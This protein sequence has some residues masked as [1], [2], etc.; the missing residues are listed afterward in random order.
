M[1][2]FK[3]VLKGI[4]IFLVVMFIIGILNPPDE[5]KK[6][7]EEPVKIAE[8]VETKET[9]KEES[10]EVNDTEKEELAKELEETKKELEE[11]KKELENKETQEEIKD[12]EKEVKEDENKPVDDTNIDIAIAIIEDS[13]KGS[14]E[15]DVNKED[16]IINLIPEGDFKT[17]VTIFISTGKNQPELHEAWDTVVTSMET[18]SEN[19]AKYDLDYIL[20]IT[21]PVN[22]ENSIL[23]AKN[24]VIIYNVVDEF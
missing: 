7:T 22:D 1:K 2:R 19:V 6:E 24:G 4:G 18:L 21:N 20:T 16:K 12:T 13:F 11:A 5:S 14:A 17:A 3:K 15:V 8:T 10:K 23:I 9:E